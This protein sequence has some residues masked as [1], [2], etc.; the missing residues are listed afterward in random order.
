MKTPSPA[1][2]LTLLSAALLTSCASTGGLHAQAMLGDANTLGAAQTLSS[3]PLSTAAWPTEAWWQTFGDQQLDAMIATALRDQ[4]TLRVAEA[5]V[6]QARASAGV[7]ASALYPQVDA[8]M[9]STR[10]R[11][12][13]N[14]TVPPPLAGNWDSFNDA[15]LGARYELD[16]WGKN[17]AA[18]DAGLDRTHASEVELQAA[19]LMLT[20]TLAG[21]YLHLDAAYAQ[22]DLAEQA[23]RQREHTL[24]L[25]QQRVAAELDSQLELTQAEAALPAA[26][27]QIAGA[28]EAIARLQNQLAA[29]Q[30]KGPDDGLRITRPQLADGDSV[31]IPSALPAEL[32]GRR[33]DLVAQRW[34]VEAARKNVKVAEAQFY[35][36]I[37]LNV[38]AG[39]QSI[40]L[41]DFLEAGSHTLGIGPALT[42]PIFEGGRLRAH[43]G[44]NQAE[45]D[46]AVETYNAT[47]VSALRDVAD[48]LVSLQWLDTQM[49][50]QDEAVRLS[51]HAY[52]LAQQ[53]YASGVASYLQVLTAEAQ[54]LNQQRLVLESSSRQRQLRLQL[55]RALGGGYTPTTIARARP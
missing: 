6:R 1:P 47:L 24:Q 45:Y 17:R 34:R 26:R 8:S 38:F 19:R 5:R 2:L 20:T 7:V 13:A 4:P 15:T 54:V 27:E 30:G 12:S 33:P 42:L 40:G 21:T 23:L 11:F 41:D 55:I 46:A 32:I 53:R 14:G 36:N 22:L 50:E 35:P 31:Q 9:K 43:L 28:R 25:T 18:V 37:S 44:V 49:H 16:F 52:A 51:R 48:Q 29:L 10:Q 39:L 3:T